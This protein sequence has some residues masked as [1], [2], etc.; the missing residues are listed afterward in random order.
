MLHLGCVALTVIVVDEDPMFVNA[1]QKSH[2]EYFPSPENMKV[3]EFKKLQD[4]K[5][6][7]YTLE[8][9]YSQGY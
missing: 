2:H 8:T 5:P 3:V 4:I 6:T 1:E 7:Y 9:N